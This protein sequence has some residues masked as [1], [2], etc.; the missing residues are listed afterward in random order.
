MARYLSYPAVSHIWA[1]IVAPDG[2][3]TIFV[4]NSTP[5]VG[6]AEDGS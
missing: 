6:I 3:V 2:K 4:E 5:I 1:F